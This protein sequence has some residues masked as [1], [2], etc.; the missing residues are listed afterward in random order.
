MVARRGGGGRGEERRQ[1]SANS[2]LYVSKIIFFTLGNKFQ[3][4][5]TDSVSCKLLTIYQDNHIKVTKLRCNVKY[6]L[7]LL[8]L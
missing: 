7:C 2:P 6:E 1:L 3:T 5:V 4:Q 8:C